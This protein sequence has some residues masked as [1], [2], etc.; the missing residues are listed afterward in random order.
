MM[1]CHLSCKD[2]LEKISPQDSALETGRNAALLTKTVHKQKEKIKAGNFGLYLVQ[3]LVN[4]Q[5]CDGRHV[6][7]S[8]WFY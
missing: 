7:P 6:R 1:L 8:V 4:I 3:H 2:V 5:L